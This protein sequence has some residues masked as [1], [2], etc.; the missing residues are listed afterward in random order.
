MLSH[1]YY[2]LLYSD[3]YKYSCFL[4]TPEPIIKP[5]KHKRFTLMEQE[6]PTTVYDME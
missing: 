5:V 1:I 2:V 3:P 6:L 4:F